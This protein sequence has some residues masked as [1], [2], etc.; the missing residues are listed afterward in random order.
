MFPIPVTEVYNLWRYVLTESTISGPWRSFH[1]RP[2]PNFSP[3]LRDKVWEGP[4][5]EANHTPAFT[6]IVMHGHPGPASYQIGRLNPVDPPADGTFQASWYIISTVGQQ[7]AMQM[8][9]TTI[10]STTHSC[11]TTL[12]VKQI[13]CFN[14][15]E[16]LP[17]L[18]FGF[19]GY[20]YETTREV[21]SL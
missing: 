12:H 6:K 1:P 4:G 21:V 8:R 9:L 20:L 19:R 14:H 10:F 7:L 2:S 13:D 3:R 11:I 18:H 17:W 16:W 15:M 5:D